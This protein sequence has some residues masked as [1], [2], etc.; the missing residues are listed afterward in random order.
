[1]RTSDQNRGWLPAMVGLQGLR[2]RTLPLAPSDVKVCFTLF[3]KYFSA[4]VHTTCLLSVSVT[5]LAFAE[6]HLRVCAALSNCTTLG[7][8]QR[9]DKRLDDT[10]GT[11]ALCGETFQNASS[12]NRKP[13]AQSL[14]YNS[15][16][17]DSFHRGFK[18]RLYPFHSPL[19]RVSQLFSFPPLN[20]MLKFSGFS[21]TA[22]VS[23]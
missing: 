20:D 22:E 19:L 11:I 18:H 3:S 16:I 12:A 5:Y 17:S 14:H 7:A 8:R 10:Y 23:L 2:T 21:C 9:S 15:T 1:M 6:V 4:F 13:A